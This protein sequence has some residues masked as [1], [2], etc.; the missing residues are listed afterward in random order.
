MYT[1][2]Y[3]IFFDA[4]LTWGRVKKSRL[5]SGIFYGNHS[6]HIGSASWHGRRAP[7]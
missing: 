5:F 2:G 7:C 3:L 4:S 6:E 1:R